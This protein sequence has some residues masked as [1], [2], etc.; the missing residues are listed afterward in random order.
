MYTIHVSAVSDKGVQRDANED[1]I[2][3][4][5]ELIRD[6]NIEKHLVVDTDAI[7]Y[8]LVADGMGGHEKGEYASEYALSQI[9]EHL[10]EIQHFDIDFPVLVER[11]GH[12]LN[13]EAKAQGQA[14]PMGCTLTGMI[15]FRGQTWLVNAGDSRTYRLRNGLLKLLTEDEDLNHRY[16][17]DL[18]DSGLA[19]YNCIGGGCESKIRTE[20]YSDKL[21]AGDMLL[22]CSDGLTDMVSDEDIERV[23]ANAMDPARALTDLANA[24]GGADN[25]SVV[26]VTIG[27][28][29]EEEEEEEIVHAESQTKA[30]GPQETDNQP[31]IADGSKRRKRGRI[32][33]FAL[34]LLLTA[35]SSFSIAR[36]TSPKG[37]HGNTSV[38]N[39]I[40]GTYSWR[41][42]DAPVS[43][44]IVI[45][46]K[47]W[48][49]TN[50]MYNEVKHEFGIVRGNIL[51]DSTGL[52][53]L[54]RV[55]G[56][57]LRYGRFTLGK[58]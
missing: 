50:I 8:A 29:V 52:I 10:D 13:T 12:E 23:C 5:G 45:H 35:I 51:Y 31:T 30:A 58:D 21:T 26:I 46:G 55:S 53:E 47:S 24:N 18:G 43:V 34:L 39:G 3:L 11:I 32:V 22:I 17:E 27:S 37:K 14:R 49:G 4:C 41:A 42:Y 19:L 9:K 20:D 2:S 25:I 36:C 44:S 38:S 7:A 28:E 57:N 33:L 54:G 40:D 1:M 15:W 16:G 56:Q 6:T 48:S